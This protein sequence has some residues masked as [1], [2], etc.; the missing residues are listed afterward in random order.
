MIIKEI[1][2]NPFV[3]APGF[4]FPA[5]VEN[6]SEV[7]VLRVIHQFL[8]NSQEAFHLSSQRPK[9]S[10]MVQ[11][12]QRLES[13]RLEEGAMVRRVT[14]HPTAQGEPMSLKWDEPA[15][16]SEESRGHREA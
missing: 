4:R 7:T 10:G 14:F 3:S 13:Y 2:K 5:G 9:A 8:L 11:S 1:K 16:K 15:V 12:L 6:V